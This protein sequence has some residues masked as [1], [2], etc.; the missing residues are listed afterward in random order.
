M[1]EI[2]LSTCPL[3]PN[4]LL[5]HVTHTMPDPVPQ[6]R[7]SHLLATIVAWR[8]AS[9][10]LEQAWHQST[11]QVNK[12]DFEG[13]GA[14]MSSYV[15]CSRPMLDTILFDREILKGSHTTAQPVTQV[16]QVVEVHNQQHPKS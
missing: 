2:C 14:T 10:R 16:G 8:V 3:L 11:R 9:R 12:Y 15:I 13:A 5:A 7:R 6:D 1:L 4:R